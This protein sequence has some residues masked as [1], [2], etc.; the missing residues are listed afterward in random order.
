[1]Y[2]NNTGECG[3]NNYQKVWAELGNFVKE[4][5]LFPLNIESFG[6]SYDDPKVTEKENCRFDACITIH[7]A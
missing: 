1:M 2:I 3:N 4:N 5:K 6:I 7:E